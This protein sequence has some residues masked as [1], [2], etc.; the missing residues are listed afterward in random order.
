MRNRNLSIRRGDAVQVSHLHRIVPRIERTDDNLRLMLWARLWEIED[1]GGH[2]IET[3]TGRDSRKPRERDQMLRDAIEVLTNAHKARAAKIARENGR[4]SPGRPRRIDVDAT[5][6]EAEAIWFSPKIAGK[7]L[8]ARLAR[9]NW[10]LSRCYREFGR[11]Q[12][13]TE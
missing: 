7:K 13:R 2:V 10:N 1:A 3:A 9:I 6:A 5:R 11:R 4:K 12:G 8:A